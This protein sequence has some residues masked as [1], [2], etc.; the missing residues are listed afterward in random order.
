MNSSEIVY[1][2]ENAEQSSELQEIESGKAARKE[3]ARLEAI[4]EAAVLMA[5]Q[6]EAYRKNALVDADAYWSAND[7]AA[8]AA[9]HKA[10][11][12]S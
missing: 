12:Q 6:M 8:L 11:G 3:L 5:E 4:A 2:I 10:I 9:Y 7:K 1:L